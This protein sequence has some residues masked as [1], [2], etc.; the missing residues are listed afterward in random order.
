MDIKSFIRYPGA[1]GHIKILDYFPSSQSYKIYCEPYG[2]S[3]AILLRKPKSWLEIYNDRNLLLINLW[4]VLQREPE[5]LAKELEWIPIS[6]K[7]FND[8]H[9]IIQDFIIKMEWGFIQD[10]PEPDVKLALNFLISSLQSYAGL[11][12]NRTSEASWGMATRYT[13]RTFP[14]I[15]ARWERAKRVLPFIAERIQ[16]VVIECQD[17][18]YILTHYDGDDTFFFCRPSISFFI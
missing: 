6:R 17:A 2:G 12:F 10:I 9:K 8:A 15:I 4:K 3:M 5:Q 16:N 14:P 13:G 18:L 11:I 1:K 7:I